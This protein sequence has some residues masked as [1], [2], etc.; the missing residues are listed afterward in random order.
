MKAF[1]INLVVSLVTTMLI[2]GCSTERERKVSDRKVAD[3]EGRIEHKLE[4]LRKRRTDDGGRDERRPWFPA[5]AN[6]IGQ[7]APAAAPPP[8]AS[9][10]VGDAGTGHVT[11]KVESE[12]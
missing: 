2:D 9:S 1:I 11:L 10:A 12:L 8:A 3:A 5:G 4:Q 6:P 7:P